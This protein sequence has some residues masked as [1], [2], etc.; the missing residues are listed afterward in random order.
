MS[1]SK[2]NTEDILVALVAAGEDPTAGRADEILL[3]AGRLVL[4]S[5]LNA[6]EL[7]SRA[8]TAIRADEAMGRALEV[9]RAAKGA[10]IDD[11]S[12]QREDRRPLELLRSVIGKLAAE[13]VISLSE[14]EVECALLGCAAQQLVID[15]ATHARAAGMNITDIY[16]NSSE[17]HVFPSMVEMA[18]EHIEEI[19]TGIR[20]GLY[21]AAENTDLQDKRD[22][23]AGFRK[24]YI[25]GQGDSPFRDD[26]RLM[27][28][29]V[30]DH[31]QDIKSGLEDRTYQPAENIDLAFKESLRAVYVGLFFQQITST[32]DDLKRF[33][34]D[35]AA[36]LHV[37]MQDTLPDRRVVGD[38]VKGLYQV[39]DASSGW[40]ELTGKGW[41]TL[42]NYTRQNAESVHALYRD[43]ARRFDRPI[44]QATAL[45]TWRFL[46][47][48]AGVDYYPGRS[49]AP[50]RH[51]GFAFTWQDA[52]RERMHQLDADAAVLRANETDVSFAN[53]V[54]P[55]VRAVAANSVD[56]YKVAMERMRSARRDR[57]SAA[58]SPEQAVE[59]SPRP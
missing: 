6:V 34:P 24:L 10:H 4:P 21:D 3:K 52:T 55:H 49:S 17:R 53:G 51:H 15:I 58:M 45:H 41:E 42:V 8:V 35:I 47:E 40:Y 30:D 20:D 7:A 25:D 22:A 46:A 19:E 14:G 23:L 1:N 59:S 56:T 38:H 33:P 32:E 31:I 39:R 43:K 44:I 50:P 16:A 5:D 11:R 36:V 57:E 28:K 12:V 54:T 26:I 29:M 48:A 37:H 27:L 18:Q 2:L 9:I 13:R